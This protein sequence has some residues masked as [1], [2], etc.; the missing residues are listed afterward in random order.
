MRPLTGSIAC[1]VLL[2]CFGSHSGDDDR[3]G[4]VGTDGASVCT[5]FGATRTCRHRCPE[6]GLDACLAEQSCHYE[7]DV[8]INEDGDVTLSR[9]SANPDGEVMDYCADGLIGAVP[10]VPPD[11]GTRGG[12]CVDPAFCAEL[13]RSGAERRCIYSDHSPFVNGPPSECPAEVPNELSHYCGVECGGCAPGPLPYMETRSACV[14]VNEERGFGLCVLGAERVCERSRDERRR[15]ERLETLTEGRFGP[16]VCMT[17]RSAEGDE[18]DFGWFAFE[19]GCRAYRAH[20]PEAIDC[21]DANWNR[22]E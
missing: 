1:L 7:M 10:M 20:F 5:E 22:V 18:P 3:D 14:G 21:R 2:G 13:E 17:Q 16:V 9:S 6:L 11:T 4:S 19:S 8:C 12:S 15:F